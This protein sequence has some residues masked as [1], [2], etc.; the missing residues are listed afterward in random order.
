ML[1]PE[2]PPLLTVLSL[3]SGVGG[4]TLA[5]FCILPQMVTGGKDKTMKTMVPQNEFG[6]FAD[7]KECRGLTV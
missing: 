5:P 2:H 7:I 3:L 6:L 4:R 1:L